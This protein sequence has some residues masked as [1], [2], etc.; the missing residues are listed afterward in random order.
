MKSA[1]PGEQIHINAVALD[2]FN[3]TTSAFI[4]ITTSAV[5]AHTSMKLVVPPILYIFSA[6]T[7]LKPKVTSFMYAT[8]DICLVYSTMILYN[9]G[10][11]GR[12]REL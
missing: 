5:S 9:L 10:D 12:N 11:K 2:Q 6:C 3:H 7:L 4:G 8:A 1:Y